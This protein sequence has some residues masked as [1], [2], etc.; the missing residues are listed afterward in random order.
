[1]QSPYSSLC[2]LVLSGQ[3]ALVSLQ[4]HSVKA[5]PLTC[6]KDHPKLTQL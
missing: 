6:A 4:R 2:H 5:L 3:G 1:M